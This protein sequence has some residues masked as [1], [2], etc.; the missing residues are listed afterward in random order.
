MTKLFFITGLAVVM[1]VSVGLQL[2]TKTPAE[3]PVTE[4]PI[5]EEFDITKV[6]S[7]LYVPTHQQDVWISV[8]EWCE[9]KGDNTAIN[10]Q[11]SDGTPSYYAFQFKPHT[12]KSYGIKYGLL[13]DDLEP[14]DYMNLLSIYEYQHEIV[15]RMVGD[16]E[17]DWHQEFPKCVQIYGLPP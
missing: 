4:Q 12:F 17:V 8:L 16:S 10:P 5:I 9:S 2:K 14:E 7:H 1:G 6:G 15:T 13:R 11:D 3:P